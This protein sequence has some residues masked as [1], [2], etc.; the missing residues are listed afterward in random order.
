MSKELGPLPEPHYN[1][2]FLSMFLH[3]SPQDC[4]T[5]DQVRAIVTRELAAERKRWRQVLSA[6]DAALAQCQPCADPECGAVQREYIDTARRAA[7]QLLTPN[8]EP[9][10]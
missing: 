1:S 6:C 10:P 5:T 9:T 4:Y 8:K 3:G 2:K 7:E